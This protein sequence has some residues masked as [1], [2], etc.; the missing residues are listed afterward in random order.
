MFIKL[1]NQVDN[2][3]IYV[4]PDW[5]MAMD[6]LRTGTRIMLAGDKV[7]VVKELPKKILEMIKN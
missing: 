7:R 2:R 1:T 6:D 3:E 4:N 5:I